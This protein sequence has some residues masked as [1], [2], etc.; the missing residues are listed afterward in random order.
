[1][2]ILFGLFRDQRRHD[3]SVGGILVP[4]AKDMNV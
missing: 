1:M 3:V 2:P 4:P